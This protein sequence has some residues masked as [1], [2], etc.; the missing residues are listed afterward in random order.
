M[1]FHNFIALHI[2]LFDLLNKLKELDAKL[3]LILNSYFSNSFF[4]TVM[5]LSREPSIW[6]P[7][8]LF[9][10]VF[11]GMNFGKRAWLW[12]LFIAL[13]ATITDQLSSSLIKY[14]VQRPRPCH[15]VSL[16]MHA[17]LLVGC[18]PSYSFTSSHATNHFGAAFFIHK[19]L[20]R[21]FHNWSYLFFFWAAL[22]SY[23]QVYVGIHYPFDVM[24]GGIIGGFIG[25]FMGSIFNRRVGLE[26]LTK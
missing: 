18:S 9:L 3:F 5:P 25:Y 12:I 20:N 24:C 22:V 1:Q 15:D 6:L 14:W 7:L 11:I 17:H 23:A 26:L 10:F 16:M 19:T 2:M 8:Y 21:Y 13:T 4:D